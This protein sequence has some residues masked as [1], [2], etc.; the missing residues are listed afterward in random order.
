MKKISNAKFG[1]FYLLLGVILLNILA[2][3]LNLRY[4]MTSEKDLPSPNR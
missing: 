3:F 4:D 1:W 2:S